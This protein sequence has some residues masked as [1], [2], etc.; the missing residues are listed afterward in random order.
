VRNQTKERELD[1]DKELKT[2]LPTLFSKAFFCTIYEHISPLRVLLQATYRVSL[3]VSVS[4]AAVMGR[5]ADG[6]R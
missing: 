3:L 1:E 4:T 6:C 2:T 5:S